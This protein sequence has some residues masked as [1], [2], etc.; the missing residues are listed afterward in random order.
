MFLLD[1]DDGNLENGTPNCDV[2]DRHVRA[3]GLHEAWKT[4]RC[5]MDPSEETCCWDSNGSGD[6][7]DCGLDTTAAPAYPYPEGCPTEQSKFGAGCTTV[8]R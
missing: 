7:D 6:D 8:V 4:E 3:A 5:P 2:I 1:D